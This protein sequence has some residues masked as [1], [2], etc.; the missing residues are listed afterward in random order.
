MTFIVPKNYNFSFKLFGMFSYISIIINIIYGFLVYFFLSI[1]FNSLSIKIYAFIIF[2]L[3]IFLL[4]IFNNSNE[5][6]LY[7]LYYLFRYL[8]RPK[9]FF[10]NKNF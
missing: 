9:L 5:N 8:I 1:I 4:T 3:P 7:V 2:F 6:L 10:Y